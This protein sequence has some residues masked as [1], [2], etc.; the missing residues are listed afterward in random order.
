MQSTKKQL[1]VAMA[2]M[3]LLLSS[4]V[5]MRTSSSTS[6]VTMAPNNVELQMK[7]SD[8]QYLGT[9][10]VTVSYNRYLGFYTIYDNINGANAEMRNVKIVDL[11]TAND[12]IPLN[13]GM[14]RALYNAMVKYPEID[15]VVPVNVLTERNQMFLGRKVTQKLRVRMYKLKDV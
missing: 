4:C 7:I 3:A 6:S 9:E 13:E 10:N 1:F 11:Q 15:F 8:Y 14:R 12:P 2:G 5:G